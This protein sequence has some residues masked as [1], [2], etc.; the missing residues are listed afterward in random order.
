[1]FFGDT[2]HRRTHPALWLCDAGVVHRAVLGV[3]RQ[4]VL[5]QFVRRAIIAE[6]SCVSAALRQRSRYGVCPLLVRVGSCAEL[7]LAIQYCA[8]VSSEYTVIDLI[9]GLMACAIADVN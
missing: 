8:E 4:L 5:W 1:M 6:A 3:L 2:E 9:I 7:T